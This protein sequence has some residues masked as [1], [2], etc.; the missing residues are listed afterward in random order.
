[1]LNKQR[2]IKW[3][4][5][6]AFAVVVCILSILV[7][8]G[9]HQS[10]DPDTAGLP[11]QDTVDSYPSTEEIAQDLNASI[12]SLTDQKAN[13]FDA[14]DIVAACPEPRI[15]I[16]DE[17]WDYIDAHFSDKRIAPQN[18]EWIFTKDPLT[19][20]RVF[21]DPVRDR[22]LV[23]EVLN[24]P[25]CDLSGVNDLRWDLYDRCHA[26]AFANFFHFHRICSGGEYQSRLSNWLE[27]G[28]GL[29]NWGERISQFDKRLELLEQKPE[30]EQR[31]L[32]NQLWEEFL[33]THWSIKNCERFDVEE[34]LTDSNRD[35]HP[36]EQLQTRSEKIGVQWKNFEGSYRSIPIRKSLSGLAA[37]YGDFWAVSGY[38]GKREWY[39][40]RNERYP[41]IKTNRILYGRDGTRESK[42]S[43]AVSI[44]VELED[45]GI[46]FDW[47]HLVHHVCTDQKKPDPQ[48][49]QDAIDAL[50]SALD[51]NEVRKGRVLDRIEG[52]AITLGVFDRTDSETINSSSSRQI[53]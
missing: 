39:D 29:L 2:M 24:D 11:V 35:L 34:I 6:A 43:A 41:W 40:R 1:M 20:G 3:S 37:Y 5:I 47:D 19:Y 23:I 36:L 45:S 38:G 14:K 33:Y 49:C 53:P 48:S 15:R 8:L 9:P 7:V 10:K 22:E 17:C 52:L 51:P 4:A 21:Q 42:L 16:T 31:Y 26:T 50:D 18:L 30:S 13:S 12:V 27:V 28:W 32:T 46:D 44:V 25:L